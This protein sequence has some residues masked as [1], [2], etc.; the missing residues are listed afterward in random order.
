MP[1]TIIEAVAT[2]RNKTLFLP[3][4]GGKVPSR[5][6]WSRRGRQRLSSE[7][8]GEVQGGIGQVERF[9]G[10]ANHRSLVI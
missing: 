5:G 3:S 10:L 4:C 7:G 6:K 8:L 9:P 1:D 2:D